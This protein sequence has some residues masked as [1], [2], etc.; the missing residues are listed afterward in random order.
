MNSTNRLPKPPIN[1]LL[2]QSD[3]VG[4][5]DMRQIHRQMILGLEEAFEVNYFDHTQLEEI[6][7]EDGVT[8]IWVGSGGTEEL[9]LDLFPRWHSPIVLLNDGISNS[10][11]ASLEI[12]S[13]LKR[14]DVEF[15]VIHDIPEQIVKEVRLLA[16]L[17]EARKQLHGQ[18]IGVI[19][20]PSDWLIASSVDVKLA[21]EKWGLDFVSIELQ[22]VLD[23][24]DCM[25]HDEVKLDEAARL[26]IKF[27]EAAAYQ[28]EGNGDE[29][30]KAVCLYLALRQVCTS[31]H[32]QAMTLRCFGLIDHCKTTGCLALAWLN[33]DGLLAGC[34]G[35]MQSIL[36][37][38]VAK[39]VTGQ[40]G[41]MANPSIISQETNQ[42]VLSHCMVD[43]SLTESY[44]IRSHY[45]TQSGIALQG[46][47]PIGTVTIFKIG[48]RNLDEHFL[49]RARLDTNTHYGHFCR[50][51][52]QFTL[53]EPVSYFLKAPIGNHHIILW[54]DY[55]EVLEQLFK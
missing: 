2:L 25:T 6:Q 40:T 14:N 42:I 20:E 7:Q 24:Y 5:N 12:A 19:G 39:A 21:R 3:L 50:T 33:Q 9:F 44:V 10:L 13:W 18:R 11:A 15:E 30:R 16:R 41:F 27:R 8:L 29:I 49:T 26:A 32:L 34:E 51:Q 31:H 53:E 54:G 37:L 45:E 35:D 55:V 28:V 23:T 1:L 22:E 52:A 17:Y 48:G 43:P 36:T 38:V 46:I 47:L 4:H